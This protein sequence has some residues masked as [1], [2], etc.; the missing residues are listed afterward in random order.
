[1]QK[2]QENMTHKEEKNQSAETNRE[3]THMLELAD[4]GTKAVII[5]V[6]CVQKT[7]Q[8]HGRYENICINQTSR[9]KKYN[10]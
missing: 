2:T 4:K 3:L 9:D 1:M 10:I 7:K 6:F 8:K 5:P